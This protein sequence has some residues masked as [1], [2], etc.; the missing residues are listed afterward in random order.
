M[1]TCSAVP[2]EPGSSSNCPCWRIS[3][4]ALTGRS[5][6]RCCQACSFPKPHASERPGPHRPLPLFGPNLNLRYGSAPVLVVIPRSAATRNLSFFQS[7]ETRSPF[8]VR[9]CGDKSQ[10]PTCADCRDG[11]LPSGVNAPCRTAGNFPANGV[12]SGAADRWEAE[13]YA[14]ARRNCCSDPSASHPLA[15][16]SRERHTLD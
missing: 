6:R 10:Q 15:A 3:W 8:G 1:Y 4:T 14:V 2:A 7:S 13:H 16:R 5:L 9:R 11:E 12:A